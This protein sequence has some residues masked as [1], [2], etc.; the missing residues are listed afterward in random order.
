MTY[1]ASYSTRYVF[2]QV[3]ACDVCQRTGR[4]AVKAAPEL[5]PIPVV[6]PWHHIRIDFVGPLS[7]PSTHGSHYIL[8]ISDYFLKWVEAIPIETKHATVVAEAQGYMYMYINYA[9]TAHKTIINPNIWVFLSL[10]FSCDLDFQ[11]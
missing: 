5:H 3:R 6:A 8:I 7:L 9:H 10:R 2:A 11:G 4:K 1:F